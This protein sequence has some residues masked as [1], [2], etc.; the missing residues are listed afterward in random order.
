MSKYI[1]IVFDGPPS[2]TS[3]RFIEV[4]DDQ[5]R[6]VSFGEWVQRPNGQWAIRVT[7]GDALAAMPSRCVAGGD[8]DGR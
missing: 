2:A 5:G 7:R 4:E 3:G 6:S 8:D 1:D